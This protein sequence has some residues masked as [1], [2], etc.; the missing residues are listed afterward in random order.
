MMERVVDAV[1]PTL[2]QD[3]RVYLGITWSDPM[4]D[5]K[6][7]EMILAGVVYLNG[8]LGASGDYEIPGEPRTL[9]FDYVRYMR[10]GAIDLFEGNY[11]HLLMQMQDE[12]RLDAYGKQKAD[13]PQQ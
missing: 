13:T 2:L 10:D 5:R 3:V 8:K 1:S 11:R 7:S 12:R 6:L 4:E 9:L